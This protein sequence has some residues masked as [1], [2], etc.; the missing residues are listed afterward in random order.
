MEQFQTRSIS[1]AVPKTRQGYHNK[2]NYRLISL[3]NTDIQLLNKLLL[4]QTQQYIERIINH[5]QVGLMQ[6]FQGGNS[7]ILTDQST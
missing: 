6:Q 3:M 7:L 2:R 4:N 1:P 5:D